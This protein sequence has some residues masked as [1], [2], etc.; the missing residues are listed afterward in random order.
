MPILW[1]LQLKE[2]TDSLFCLNQFE[3]EFLSLALER[4]LAVTPLHL[5]LEIFESKFQSKRGGCQNPRTENW[6]GKEME[7]EKG[8]MTYCGEEREKSGS[9]QKGMGERDWEFC[10]F[11]CSCLVWLG[12]NRNILTA[13]FPWIW[14]Q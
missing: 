8:N 7:E 3:L 5:A 11:G 14:D 6:N 12:E 4:F 2:L 13:W 1:T 9:T 10:P